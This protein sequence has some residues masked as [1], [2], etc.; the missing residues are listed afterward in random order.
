[1]VFVFVTC[2]LSLLSTPSL[3]T[4]AQVFQSRKCDLCFGDLDPPAMYF[5]CKHSF[6]QV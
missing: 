4:N 6:H 3:K 5:M 2:S 1:M